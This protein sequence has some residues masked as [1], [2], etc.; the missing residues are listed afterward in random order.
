MDHLED[1]LD[2]L[3]IFLATVRAGSIRSAARALGRSQP[4]VSR[5]IRLLEDATGARLFVRDPSGI[6]LTATGQRLFELADHVRAGLSTFRARSGEEKKIRQKISLGTYESIA[7]YF[8]PGFLRYAADVQ[9]HLEI[10]LYTAPSALLFDALRRSAV[11]LI[12]SVNPPAH[13]SVYSKTLFS[14]DYRVYRHQSVT[15]AAATP[16]LLFRDAT[17]AKG[18]TIAK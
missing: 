4:A 16:L 18:K 14:D 9:N 10:S 8:L 13:R 6:K 7:V 17:D 11:D 12:V 2:K 15:V 1:H 3:P 5:T